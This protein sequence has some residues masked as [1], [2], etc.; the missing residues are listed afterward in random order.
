MSEPKAYVPSTSVDAGEQPVSLSYIVRTIRSYLPAIALAMAAVFL[1]CVLIGTA[2]YV[3]SPSQRVTSL[4]FRLDFAGAEK[5]EYPNGL[6]FTSTEIVA[7]PILVKT[8]HQNELKRFTTLPLFVSSVFVLE[9]NEAQEEL[10]REYQARLSD[11]RLTSIDRERIQREYDLKLA[12]LSRNQFTINYLRTGKN[13]DVPEIVARK[14]LSDI[15]NN[16][17]D[18]ATRDQHAFEYRVAVLSPEIVAGGP[19][20]VRN[21]IITTVML[22][23]KVLRLM[24]NI[25]KI[26]EVMPNVELVRTSDGLTLTDLTVRLDELIRY[27]L[28]P[29]I[30][31][32]A[33]ARLDNRAET[34]EFL[35]TQLAYDE[36]RLEAQRNSAETAQRTLAMYMSA[37]NAPDAA[38]LEGAPPQPTPTG[39]T[40]NVVPQLSETFIDRLIQLTLSSADTTYRQRL[41]D[42]YR[43]L[44][45]EMIPVQQAV[46]YD[47]ATLENIS[48]GTAGSPIDR[49]T[50]N[51]Q[52][53]AS[54]AEARMLATKVHE[55]HALASRNL[56]PS[57]EL[58]SPSAPITRVERSVSLKKMALY[59]VLI[60][61][62]SFI[63]ALVLS[64]LHSRIRA[65]EVAEEELAAEARVLP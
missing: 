23:D 44:S 17:A 30:D 47:R 22:R 65:E 60:L 31:G 37:T 33:A 9:S 14:V 4:P 56:N 8:F 6:K 18:H 54:R 49:D 58:L 34:I 38:A 62:F 29:L 36:R 39:E 50:A 52:I 27:R 40:R 13:D 15:L 20:D 32:I 64:L 26:R 55:I 11:A 48:S 28:D 57:T 3:F 43:R 19:I 51:A 16:W 35:Q 2:V 41:T 46:A 63:V 1:G 59:A 42:E 45:Y 53:A 7:Q 21:P 24:S 12:S 10:A 25:I 5:G 61:G